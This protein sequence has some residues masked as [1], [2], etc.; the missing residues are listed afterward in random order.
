MEITSPPPSPQKPWA[1]FTESY[2]SQEKHVSLM[3][4]VMLSLPELS[5]K[6]SDYCYEVKHNIGYT[7]LACKSKLARDKQS[8]AISTFKKQHTKHCFKHCWWQSNGFVCVQIILGYSIL[9]EFSSPRRILLGLAKRVFHWKARMNGKRK[10][11]LSLQ[12]ILLSTV[13]PNIQCVL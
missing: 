11:V 13:K 8:L 10:K 2:S 6:L 9:F 12:V 7:C 5:C 4:I 1:V 3:L